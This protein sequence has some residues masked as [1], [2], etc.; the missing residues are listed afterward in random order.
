LTNLTAT[1]VDFA[2]P[3]TPGSL[4]KVADGV[5]WTRFAIP[6]ALS[7][8]N[9]YLIEDGDEWAAV[10]TGLGDQ[11]TKDVWTALLSGPLG[12]RRLSRLIITHHHPDH[13]GLA[14]W[15]AEKFDAPIHMT[16]A[17]FLLAQH[18]NQNSN[19]IDERVYRGLY[20]RH[21]MPD[22]SA[23]I[24]I[25][26][27]RRF[28]EMVAPIPWTYRQLAAGA[29][30]TIG[31]RRF[32]IL[33]GGGHSSEQAMLFSQKDGLFLAADQVLPRISPNISVMAVDPEGDPL[34]RYLRSLAQIKQVVPDGVLVLPGHHDPFRSL[35]ERIDA[36]ARHHE[37]RCE[38][39]EAACR[40]EPR[41][42]AE[43][44]PFLF[45]RALDPHQMSFAFSETLAHMNMMAGEGRLTWNVD[46][47][48]A[49]A[50]AG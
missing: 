39:V 43:V 1:S 10:D 50:W 7:H 35:H 16:E 44:V 24:L 14:G 27:G 48:A 5:L 25:S 28:K 36:L 40:S 13:M 11:A 21:G 2:D 3:P 32:E 18:L 22:H 29:S 34:G 38:I 8:V 49:R 31:A 4:V 20:Q 46:Q 37:D 33:T 26:Q 19:F 17:E 45:P 12:G 6:F 41:T 15:L 47:P 42:A 23:D 30:L 9:V